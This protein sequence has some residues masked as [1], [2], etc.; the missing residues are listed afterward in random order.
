MRFRLLSPL[1][2]L[3]LGALAAPASAGASAS[4]FTVFD[5]PRE[6]KGDDA[7]LRTQTLDELQALGVRWLRVTLYWKDVAPQ[8]EATRAPVFDERDPDEGY[9]WER[10]DPVIREARARGMQILLTVSGPV[11]KWATRDKDDFVTEPSPLRFE[12]FTTAVGRRYGDDVSIWAVWNEPNQPNFLLPQFRNGKAASPAIYRRLFQAADRGLRAAGQGDDP[13]LAGETAPRGTPLVVAPVTFLR[14]TL[15]LDARFRRSPRCGRLPADGWAHHPYTTQAGPFFVPARSTDVTIG[16]LG[17]LTSA[18]RKA[19]RAGA[20]PRNQ[21]VYIT[22]FGVQSEPDPNVG[23]P[24]PVQ[25]EQRSIAELIALRNPRVRSFAQYLMRDDFPRENLPASR[26]YSGF[27]SGLREAAG[28]VKPAYEGFRLPLVALRGRTRTSLWGLVR[29]ATGPTAVEVE[30]R[31]RGGAWRRLTVRTTSA[32]GTW[33]TTTGLKA[34]RRYRV[35]WTAPDGT[36]HVG[37]ATRSYAPR[38]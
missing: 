5:A 10:Y 24:Q 36:E 11:P 1:L 15:C 32:R 33:S 17:R 4:Q 35:R 38:R 14:G 23:V 8:A 3:L 12:R 18:L 28:A 34:S 20:L 16:V 27:E 21:G 30:Y 29:P 6:L 7:G 37:P 25:A 26:R 2:V 9:S 31:D 13:V 19:E 22:E